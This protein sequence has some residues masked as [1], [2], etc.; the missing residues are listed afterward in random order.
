MAKLK[1]RI[2]VKR[3]FWPN[4]EEVEAL[5]YVLGLT[6][7]QRYVWKKI[8][9]RYPTSLVSDVFYTNSWKFTQLKNTSKRVKEGVK[10]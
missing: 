5:T 4:Q 1:L 10:S 7:L 8:T 9:S 2:L 6:E 3:E